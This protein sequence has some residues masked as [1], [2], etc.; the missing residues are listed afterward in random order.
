MSNEK[1]E[2]NWPLTILVW[3]II[4]SVFASYIIPAIIEY[5][6]LKHNG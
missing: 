3:V 6:K 1:R 4:L 5:K 2:V